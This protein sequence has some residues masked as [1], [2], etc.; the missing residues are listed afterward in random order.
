MKTLGIATAVLALA[1]TSAAAEWEL[2][3]TESRLAFGS[4]KNAFIGE[5]HSFGGLS[6]SVSNAGDVTIQIGLA[7]VQTNIDIRNERMVEHVF[8]GTPAATINAQI[9]MDGI[10]KLR[11]GES[12]IVESDVDVS[13]LGED[14]SVFSELYVVRTSGRSVMVTTNDMVFVDTEQLGIDAGITTLQE[15]AG[16]D[17]ITRAVPVSLRFVFEK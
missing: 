9:D 11:P 2:N 7:D 12:M 16:L 6:G 1:A 10:K 15:L 14:V 8:A 3:A 4:V 17:S 13:F 5:V